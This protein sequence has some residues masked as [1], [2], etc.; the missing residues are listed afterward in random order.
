MQ[1]IHFTRVAGRH[2]LPKQSQ[3]GRQARS[4]DVPVLIADIFCCSH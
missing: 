4:I 1:K 2:K 3:A